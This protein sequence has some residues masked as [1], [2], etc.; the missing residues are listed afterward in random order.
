MK[1]NI[2]TFLLT[3]ALCSSIVKAEA[4]KIMTLQNCIE[5]AF[6]H[7]LELK[8]GEIAVDKAEILQKTAVELDK[9]SFSISQDPTSGGSPDNSWS[10]SQSFS[11]PTIYSARRRALKSE[12]SLRKK[13]L[14]VARHD[15]VK[16]VTQAYYTLL[17]KRD[18]MKIYEEQDTIYQ[19]FLKLAS[20]KYKLGEAGQLEKMNAERLYSENKLVW[21]QVEKDFKEAQLELQ[22]RMGT[23]EDVIPADTAF[24]IIA[25]PAYGTKL[26]FDNTPWADVLHQQQKLSENNLAVEKQGYLPDFSVS[27]SNQLVF[28]SFNPYNVD[29][30]RFEKGNFMGFEVSISIPLFFGAQKAKVKAAKQ[31][32][33][34]NKINTQQMEYQLNNQFK[35]ALNEYVRA[36][37]NL[38]YYNKEGNPEADRMLRLSKISYEKGEIGYIEYIQ[39]L[40]TVAD[41]HL[42]YAQALNTY[43]QSVILLNYLQGK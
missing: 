42:R 5:A 19:K 41:I 28:K 20:D 26:D 38:D 37:K 29:R 12:T 8:A 39:N 25:M 18:V 6:E 7:N 24:S 4:Q 3:I 23:D 31:E 40:Q 15:V 43:N 32:L 30:S 1:R 14:A 13:D 22:R 16:E 33:L 35:Q 21:H 10:V 2:Y 36:G 27:V 17:Y 34:L 11:F 9:T